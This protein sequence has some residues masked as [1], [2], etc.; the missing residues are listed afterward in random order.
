MMNCNACGARIPHNAKFCT[1][2]GS[3]AKRLIRSDNGCHACGAEIGGAA[4][5]CTRCGIP[6][7]PVAVAAQAQHAASSAEIDL[8]EASASTAIFTVDGSRANP[9]SHT[10]EPAFTARGRLM[11]RNLS[12]VTTIVLLCVVGLG[13]NTMRSSAVRVANRAPDSSRLP[14]PGT[15]GVQPMR[16]PVARGI[17][18][19]PMSDGTPA[20]AQPKRA[21][22]KLW[23]QQRQREAPPEKQ[24]RQSAQLARRQASSVD[25]NAEHRGQWNTAAGAASA[26]S[27]VTAAISGDA[28]MLQSNVAQLQA[29]QPA[30]G[31]RKRARHLNHQGLA[32]FQR[33]NYRGAAEIFRQAHHADT[34]DAEIRENLGYSLMQAGELAEAERALLSALE[35]APQRATAWGSLGHIYAKR[36]KHREAVALLLTAH[37]F[38]P[39]RRKALEVYARQAE[40][41]DDPK[42]RAMLAE[43]VTRLSRTQ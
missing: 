13:V 39:D 22:A 14:D 2:C 42:V 34:G 24:D 17:E 5:F 40:N 28:V 43:S 9:T 19:S 30:R 7:E 27:L 35:I 31:D 41:E 37:R 8:V 33:A 20:D 11:R 29:Q 18:R 21:E 6:V 3:K 36:G 12:V 32:L 1:W 16:D 25:T 38:A 26:R 15:A 10:S 4:N 23:P